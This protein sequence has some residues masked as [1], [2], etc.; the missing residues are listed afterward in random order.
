MTQEQKDYLNEVVLPKL[1]KMA[2][3]DDLPL[4]V[5]QLYAEHFEEE[6]KQYNK[7]RVKYNRALNALEFA[8]F[9]DGD[10]VEQVM[11]FL[12]K[13]E[14][15]KSIEDHEMMDYIDGITMVERYEYSFT[16]KT[17]F[18]TITPSQNF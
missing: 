13:L 9:D 17:F 4:D 2:I 6:S 12:D 5:T 7:N 8:I 15:D 3:N 18:E 10:T 1:V 16:V 11:D 14:N